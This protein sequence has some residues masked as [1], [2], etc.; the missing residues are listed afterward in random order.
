MCKKAW[1][2]CKVVVLLINLLLCLLFSLPSPSPSPSSLLKLSIRH[3]EVARETGTRCLSKC[4]VGL[5]WGTH[6]QHGGK[7]VPQN[8]PTMHFDN[9]LD[10][11]SRATSNCLLLW[12]RNFATMVM[13]RHT[14]PSLLDQFCYLRL[15]LRIETASCHLLQRVARWAWIGATFSSVTTM[16]KNPPPPQKKKK[17]K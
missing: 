11:V 17:N 1:C 12:S 4:I 15:Y 10:P 5:F 9:H 6:F 13:W 16:P 2:T 3:F 14:G 7:F 8:S